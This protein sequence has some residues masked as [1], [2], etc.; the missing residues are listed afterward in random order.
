MKIF[1]VAAFLLF[2]SFIPAPNKPVAKLDLAKFS[3]K[4]YSLYSIP[5]PFDKDSY[6]TTTVYTL[7]ADGYYNVHT[8]GRKT[9]D[10]FTH[11]FDSK[12]F[13]IEGSNNGHLKAQF[14]WPFRVDYW[15][16]DLADD[17]SW[18]VVGHPDK[19]F[20]FIMSRKPI[21]DKNLYCQIVERCKQMGYPVEKLTCQ[22]HAEA[23][24]ASK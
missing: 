1:F 18:A 7:N 8:Y 23:A 9:T 6:Q 15:V 4:W 13:P 16:I 22:N 20:L 3:G 11:T 19:K 24:L 10:N 14:I 2:T 12:L 21:M 17:Y 5:T